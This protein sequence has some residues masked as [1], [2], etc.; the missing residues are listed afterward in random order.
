MEKGNEI[1]Y[2]TNGRHFFVAKDLESIALAEEILRIK[3]KDLK[4][5][6]EGEL[7]KEYH[8]SKERAKNFPDWKEIGAYLLIENFETY[9][10]FNKYFNN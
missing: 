2:C 6:S 5:I 8:W 4:F 1:Y 7:P 10:R 3:N 9:N